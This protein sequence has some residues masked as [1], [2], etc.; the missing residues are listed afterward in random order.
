MNSS[1]STRSVALVIQHR[2]TMLKVVHTVH[3][4]N[5]I[6]APSIADRSHWRKIFH[7][8]GLMICSESTN[9][10]EDDVNLAEVVR[11]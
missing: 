1:S 4:T 5:I 3:E 10:N 11:S 9:I 7:Y 6:S 8:V 2:L